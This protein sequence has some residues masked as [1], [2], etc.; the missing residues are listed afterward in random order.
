MLLHSMKQL[1]LGVRVE[2]PDGEG[3]QGCDTF[4]NRGLRS[5]VEI[6]HPWQTLVDINL[7]AKGYYSVG[8]GNLTA[9]TSIDLLSATIVGAH[10]CSES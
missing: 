7:W 9:G 5:H 1:W 4:R 2:L 6:E 3:V 10:F 8:S